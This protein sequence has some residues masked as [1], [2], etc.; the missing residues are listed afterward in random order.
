M[1]K[2]LSQEEI[3]A[4]FQGATAAEPARQMQSQSEIAAFDFHRLDRIPK[5]QLQ[6]LH[7]IHENFVRSLASSLSAYLRSYVALNLVSLEQISYGEFLEGLASP[8]CIA[9]LGLQPYD[10]KAVLELS[11]NLV[12]GLIELLLGSKGRASAPVNRKITDIEKKLVQT[13]LRVVL[14]DLSEAW[15]NVA[16][17]AF[18]VQSLASEPTILYVLSPGEAVIV[19]AVEVRVGAASGLMNLAIPSIFIKRLRHKFDQLQKI[20]KVESTES[21]QQFIAQLIQ[22]SKLTLEVQIPNGVIS[23]KALVGLE[24]GEVIV[25]DHPL[26]REVSGFLN[27]KE[28]W[29]GNVTVRGEK[30]AFEVSKPS[31]VSSSPAYPFALSTPESP[32][33]MQDVQKAAV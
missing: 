30:V 5:S 32:A 14:R 9:Y 23:A 24:P 11:N 12:F 25:L 13:L 1:K 2:V 31:R 15:K 6:S 19:I 7:Q 3:D 18:S 4:V 20:R 28:K 27:G 16:D 26:D 29:R 17:I 21:D 8:T 22:D 10:G 33:S